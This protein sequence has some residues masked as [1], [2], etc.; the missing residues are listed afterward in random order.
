MRLLK[1]YGLENDKEWKNASLNELLSI[2]KKI[3]FYHFWL[4]EYKRRNQ[5]YRYDYYNAKDSTPKH[6][7]W[8][9]PD[10]G[11]DPEKIL[12]DLSSVTFERR[13]P[14]PSFWNNDMNVGDNQIEFKWMYDNIE[15]KAK[16]QINCDVSFDPKKLCENIY[17][18]LLWAQEERPYID[19]LFEKKYFGWDVDQ[20]M[21]YVDHQEDKYGINMEDTLFEIYRNYPEWIDEYIKTASQDSFRDIQLLQKNDG[22]RK[23]KNSDEK[24]AIGLWLRDFIVKNECSQAEAIRNLRNKIDLSWLGSEKTEDRKFHHY[25]KVTVQC[26]QKCDVLPL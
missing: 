4:W 15:K 25:Y 11:Y 3:P 9:D 1:E 6:H 23:P 10:V 18:F 17:N 2:R 14:I 16:L 7:K 13:E 22:R 20:L 8:C 26:I 21:D 12:Q 24:R 5:R 19:H